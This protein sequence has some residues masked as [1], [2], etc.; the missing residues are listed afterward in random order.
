[1]RSPPSIKTRASLPLI[2]CLLN[3]GDCA[4]GA[5]PEA[6]TQRQPPLE[7][8]PCVPATGCRQWTVRPGLQLR[9]AVKIPRSSAGLPLSAEK[10]SHGEWGLGKAWVGSW[11]AR[12]VEDRTLGSVWECHGDLFEQNPVLWSKSLLSTA[13]PTRLVTNHKCSRQGG[14][15]TE[16]VSV[17]N[18]PGRMFATSGEGRMCNLTS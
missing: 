7:S 5:R 9:S 15:R 12:I 2:A 6:L 17:P 13:Y 10:M 3:A 8:A 14:K 18:S 16:G 11:L 4:V 1:M